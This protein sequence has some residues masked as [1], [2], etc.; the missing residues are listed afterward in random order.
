M[1]HHRVQ[2]EKKKLN[3]DIEKLKELHHKY[4]EKYEELSQKYA[5]AM[6]EKMLL[7]LERDRLVSKNEALQKSLQNVLS[8][9]H[10]VDRRE[11][12]Q[13]VHLRKRRRTTQ[14]RWK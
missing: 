3:Y 6:K 9:F 11:D 14:N 13:G 8:A 12:G 4:E 5:H 10:F 2:Q 7:K 1:H